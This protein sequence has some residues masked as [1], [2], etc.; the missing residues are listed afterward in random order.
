MM[1]FASER[2]TPAAVMSGRWSGW[3]LILGLNASSAST[4][5]SLSAA[6]LSVK[7]K[8]LYPEGNDGSADYAY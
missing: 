6:F 3:G 8:L 5:S 4:V 7:S 1:W 2:S